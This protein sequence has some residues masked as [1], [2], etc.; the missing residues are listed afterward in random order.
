MQIYEYLL[1]ICVFYFKRLKLY[2]LLIK[3]Q[4]WS[5]KCSCEAAMQ[6][7]NECERAREMGFILNEVLQ[8]LNVL[9][10]A[11]V[12][13]Q[14]FCRPPGIQLSLVHKDKT[15]FHLQFLSKKIKK[16]QFS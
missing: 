13:L 15:L 7:Q 3:I 5:G 2:V 12:K 9:D 6:L 16:E 14:Y 1:N 8:L 4:V 10:R 11:C